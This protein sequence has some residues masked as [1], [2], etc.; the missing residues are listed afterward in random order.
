M[1]LL[2]RD[3]LVRQLLLDDYVSRPAVAY[4]QPVHVHRVAHPH[5]WHVGTFDQ[6]LSDLQNVM[7]SVNEAIGHYQN[8][9]AHDLQTGGMKTSRTEDGNLQLAVDVSQFKPEEVNVK[10]CDDNLV[11]EAKSETSENDNYHK[12]ELKRWIRLPADVKHDA[13]KSTLTPDRKL[14]IEVPMN[15]P[16]ADSRSRSIPIQ[17]QKEPIEGTNNKSQKDGADQQ[18]QSCPVKK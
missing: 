10:L 6:A 9:L 3:P 4:R 11:I 13:I 2:L 17:V 12:A 7:S 5:D 16:I 15:K 8:S 1:S 18:N 14:M